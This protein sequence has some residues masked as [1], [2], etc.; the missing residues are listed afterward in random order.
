M[1]DKTMARKA[2]V[3]MDLLDI[4]ARD[5]TQYGNKGGMGA[6]YRKELTERIRHRVLGFAT[7]EDVG[8]LTET[9]V[10]ARTMLFDFE[11]MKKAAFPE[12]AV[13]K[14][15]AA[16]KAKISRTNSPNG[17]NKTTAFKTKA[18]R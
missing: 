13:L 17:K 15:L 18:G 4:I 1:N 14:D 5:I 12:K 6:Y 8:Y 11:D 9:Q 10:N 7:S 2:H 3:I 16:L